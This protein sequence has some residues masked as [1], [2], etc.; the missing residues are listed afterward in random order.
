MRYKTWLC[1][2][3]ITLIGG[4][5]STTE[6]PAMPVAPVQQT[7]SSAYYNRGQADIRGPLGV[8]TTQGQGRRVALVIGNAAYAAPNS[9]ASYP[10][11]CEFLSVLKNPL[12]DAEDMAAILENYGFK[13]LL[14]RDV[15]RIQ[16]KAAIREFGRHSTDAN[17]ALLFYAGHAVQ[18]KSRNYLLPTDAVL[19]GEVDF[20]DQGIS[21]N[22]VMEVLEQAKTVTN[23]VMLDACR[24]NPFGEHRGGSGGYDSFFTRGS[25]SGGLAEVSLTQGTVVAYAAAPGQGAADNPTERNGLFTAGLKYAFQQRDLSL[26]G[27]LTN[28]SRWVQGQSKGHQIPYVNGPEPLKKDFFFAGSRVELAAAETQAAQAAMQEQ[29]AAK[30]AQLAELD[31][32]RIAK[33]QEL[34]AVRKAQIAAEQKRQ[35]ALEAARKAQIA[36]DAARNQAQLPVTPRP[37]V[38]PLVTTTRKSFEP[39]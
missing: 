19:C 32:Q 37:V 36:A 1:I 2:P 18:G 9:H 17:T 10:S 6:R 16:M 12:H 26:D 7:G 5:N 14:Y 23:L 27:I 3:I 22:Y 20:P 34:E 31:R 39:E 4:C 33:E 13:V 8:R 29:L 25:F 15:N 24:T 38:S 11:D 21:L 28:A 35:D 30:Q